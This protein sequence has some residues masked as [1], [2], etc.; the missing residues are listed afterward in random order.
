M[1]APHSETASAQDLPRI[2]AIIAAALPHEKPIPT[3]ALERVAQ[4][5]VDSANDDPWLSFKLRAGLDS[6]D[7]LVRGSFTDLDTDAAGRV[8][9][10]VADA[11]FFVHIRQTAIVNLYEDEDVWE[12][13]GYE[14]PSFDQGGYLHRGFDDLDWLPT[15]RIEEYDGPDEWRDVVT[16]LPLGG[17][18]ATTITGAVPVGEGSAVGGENS[19]G[20]EA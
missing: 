5:V 9:L 10:H 16:D 4:K 2:V 13:L 7:G 15:P 8:L 18:A 3:A 20:R 19:T 14:G 6:L 12:V 17:G 1:E 11:D